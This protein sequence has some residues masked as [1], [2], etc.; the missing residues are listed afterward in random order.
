MIMQL[1]DAV[2]QLLR[3]EET[4]WFTTV[5]ADGQPQPVPVWFL[6]DGGT[7]LIY[8]QP[9]NQKL[10][11]IQANGRVSLNLGRDDHV[12]RFEGRAEIAEDAPPATDVP[13]YVE[14]YRDGIARIGMT[15]ESFATAYSVPIRVRPTRFYSW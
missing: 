6:W 4:I 2:Q 1:S 8:S 13:E 14:K 15:P 7:F 3:E 12:V 10:R 11:N 5:R 9:R